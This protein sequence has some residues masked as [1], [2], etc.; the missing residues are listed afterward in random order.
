MRIDL[1]PN[2]VV[3]KACDANHFI[4]GNGEKVKGKLILTNQRVYF[5]TDGQGKEEFNKEILP[6]DISEVMVFNTRIFLPNGLNII[7]KDGD[8]VRFSVKKRDEWCQ[9]INSLC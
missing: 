1:K 2:E 5:K 7:Q 8:Q 6:V 3:T 4:N 9:M